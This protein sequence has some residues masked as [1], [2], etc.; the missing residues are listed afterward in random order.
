MERMDIETVIQNT[1]KGISFT[2]QLMESMGQ[3]DTKEYEFQR[4]RLVELKALWNYTLHPDEK[5]LW[6]D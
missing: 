4:G 5:E 2:L 1:V 6:F 3:K